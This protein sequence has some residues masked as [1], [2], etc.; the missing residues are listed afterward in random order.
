[1]N[2]LAYAAFLS[3]RENFPHSSAIQSET[4][5]FLRNA[6]YVTLVSNNLKS[7]ENFTFQ[8][9]LTIQNFNKTEK[10]KNP[11]AGYIL[12]I[13]DQKIG[14]YKLN[15][16]PRNPNTRFVFNI[17][18]ENQHLLQTPY[19]CH[20]LFLTITANDLNTTISM[21]HCKGI[22]SMTTKGHNCVANVSF[23]DFPPNA[24][25][26]GK[27][28][29]GTEGKVIQ[30]A[31]DH[32]DFKINYVNRHE[33][34]WGTF[35]PPTGLQGDIATGSS[36]A[37]F[38]GLYAFVERANYSEVVF[39]DSVTTL[40]WAVPKGVG[41]SKPTWSIILFSEFSTTVWIITLL[42]YGAIIPNYCVFV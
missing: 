41:P 40:A 29:D 12:D 21:D 5:T 2:L 37:A 33:K 8:F 11:P 10:Q 4:I 36:L 6:N 19:F 34:G 27:E 32:F 38:G 25:F 35:D 14:Y 39:G 1:M 24:I 16:L 13:R 31:A 9:P 23:L 15:L 42:S 7:W 22:G 28:L 17:T 3:F 20:A 26:N 18:E 30:T